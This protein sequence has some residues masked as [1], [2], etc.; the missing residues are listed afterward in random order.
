M[1]ILIVAK[2]RQGGGACVGGISFDGRS[3][4]LIPASGDTHEGANLEYNVG[5]VWEVEAAAPEQITP[6]HVE[7]I[8]VQNKRRLGPMTG[9]DRFIERHMPPR[10]G[11]PEMLYEGLVQTGAGGA[12]YIAERCG[13]PPYSTLFWRPDQPLTRTHDGPSSSAASFSRASNADFAGP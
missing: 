4:R 3:V 13:V 10:A 6:P 5:E 12:L 11:G 9:F 7:N 1:K 2:T 8:V